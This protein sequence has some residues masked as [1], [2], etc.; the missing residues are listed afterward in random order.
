VRRCL[1]RG[2]ITGQEVRSA[3]VDPH[4]DDAGRVEWWHRCCTS[5]LYISWVRLGVS[6]PLGGDL[7]LIR[8]FREGSG[9]AVNGLRKRVLS[10]PAPLAV[11]CRCALFGVVV[12]PSRPPS[13]HNAEDLAQY[14][15]RLGVAAS[16]D[17]LG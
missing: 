13:N 7:G 4:L 5:L 3:L 14:L 17:T 15:G 12:S 6:R 8:A 1:Q 16:A 9:G 11:V 2:G 10:A